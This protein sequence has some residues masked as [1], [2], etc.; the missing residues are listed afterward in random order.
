MQYFLFI[1]NYLYYIL[2]IYIFLLYLFKDYFLKHFEFPV[3]IQGV[4]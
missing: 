2:H 4:I 3:Y 1:F